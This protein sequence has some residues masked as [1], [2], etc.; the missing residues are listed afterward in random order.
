MA[1]LYADTLSPSFKDRSFRLC[2][3]HNAIKTFASN[4]YINTLHAQFKSKALLCW[5]T[6]TFDPLTTT[7]FELQHEL[8][9]KRITSVHLVHS[10]FEQIDKYEPYLHALISQ[11][12]RANVLQVA[13]RLDNERSAGDVR[14]PLH[15]IPL[16]IKVSQISVILAR[17]LN[18]NRIIWQRNLSLAWT[19]PPGASLWSEVDP[20]RMLRL[21]RRCYNIIILLAG[22]HL[23]RRS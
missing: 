9:T 3:S 13:R 19:R 1:P 23:C 21:L 22:A 12:L 10:C 20:E 2:S 16:L 11:P 8:E 7:I 14:G 18:E 6:M 5:A 15:G 4:I 17:M